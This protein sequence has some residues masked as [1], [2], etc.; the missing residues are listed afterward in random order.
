MGKKESHDTLVDTSEKYNSV[1][2]HL[3]AAKLSLVNSGEP[4]CSLGV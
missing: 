2:C 3:D 1:E 4:S